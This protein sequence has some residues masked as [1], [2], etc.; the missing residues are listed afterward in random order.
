MIYL[1]DMVDI[2]YWDMVNMVDMIYLVD[3][4]NTVDMIFGRYDK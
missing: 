1:V 2:I 3:M 4:T